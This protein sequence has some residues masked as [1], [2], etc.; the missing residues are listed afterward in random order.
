MGTRLPAEH[1]LRLCGAVPVAAAEPGEDGLDLG[2]ALGQLLHLGVGQVRPW[3][4]WRPL[5]P[6]PR[7]GRRRSRG[8]ASARRYAKEALAGGHFGGHRQQVQG[9]DV[10]DVDDLKRD[11]RQR[12][13]LAAQ[14]TSDHLGPGT[15]PSRSG[16]STGPST[17]PG[18]TVVSVVPELRLGHE[19]PRRL[20]SC[21]LRDAVGVHPGQRL[22]GP[23]CLVGDPGRP[24][25]GRAG[26]VGGGEGVMTTRS[27][28]AATAAD[29]TRTANR[30]QAPRRPSC[31]RRRSPSAT[32]GE[33]GCSTYRQPSTA[34]AQPASSLRLA[35]ANVGSAAVHTGFGDRPS[36]I[37][38]GGQVANGRPHG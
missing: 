3:G 31:R 21:G 34:S 32:N 22:V 29:R 33:A 30:Q 25:R 13:L 15:D 35:T 12:V 24:V 26:G 28:P 8:R 19:R 38:L 7:A 6:T 9:S 23:Q 2:T 1:P 5:R 17:A 18:S 27:T 11:A 20:L 4:P 10:A 37:G 14:E 36:N 16:P